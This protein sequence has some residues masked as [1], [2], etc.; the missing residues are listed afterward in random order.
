MSALLE[1]AEELS[2]ELDSASD[3]MTSAEINRYMRITQKM[4]SIAEDLF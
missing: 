4:T 3:E 1:E 2:D